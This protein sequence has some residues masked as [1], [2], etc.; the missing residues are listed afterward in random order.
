MTLFMFSQ[1]SAL[2]NRLRRN[3]SRKIQRERDGALN[4]LENCV[5]KFSQFSFESDG[6]DRSDALHICKGFLFEKTQLGKGYFVGTSPVLNRQGDIDD[7]CARGR[8]IVARQDYNR[9]GFRGQPEIRQPHFTVM[10]ARQLCPALPAQV[11]VVARHRATRD[12]LVQLFL[13]FSRELDLRPQAATRE[14]C[15]PTFV[16]VCP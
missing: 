8:R 16:K 4:L 5:R 14:V 3:S 10:V 6:W 9:P 7:Q 11:R 12:R 13:R 1:Q 15:Y 2:V